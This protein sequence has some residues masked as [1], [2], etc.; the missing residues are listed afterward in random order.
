M[1]PK[2]A[3][4][5]IGIADPD[6]CALAIF[7]LRFAGHRVTRADTAD[8]LV[9]Q[10]KQ[11]QAELV[12]MEANFGGLDEAALRQAL[13]EG[14]R[15]TCILYV[16]EP[17]PDAPTTP[18]PVAIGYIRKPISADLLT[19]KVNEALKRKLSVA[20][21]IGNLGRAEKLGKHPYP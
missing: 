8:D 5:L 7:A 10:L 17:S 19:R 20:L 14:S 1:T 18:R 3:D 12:L 16:G 15:T 21:P 9:A 13:G 2:V 11:A 6:E 4:I